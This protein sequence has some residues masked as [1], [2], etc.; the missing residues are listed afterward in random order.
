[1]RK[2]S[3]FFLLSE[4]GD[5]IKPTELYAMPIINEMNAY[6]GSVV[7]LEEVQQ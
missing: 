7:F 2:I 4:R 6:M 5:T 3:R 1:M